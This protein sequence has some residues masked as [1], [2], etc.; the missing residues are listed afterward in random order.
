MS[1]TRLAASDS[2]IDEAQGANLTSGSTVDLS[3]VTGNFVTVTG[4]T[5][6]TAFGTAQAGA[7]RILHFSGVLTLTHNATSLILPGG[8]NI[9]T[10]AGDVAEMVSL[11]SG[12]W[13]CTG[14]TLVGTAPVGLAQIQAIAVAL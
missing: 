9:T 11:G 12:N 1:H 8:A 6:I 5:T 4:T 14:Y 3:G 10:A 2:R 7:R 13:R